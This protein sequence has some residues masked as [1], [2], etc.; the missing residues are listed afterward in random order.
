MSP[1]SDALQLFI[2]SAF[3]AFDHFAQAP[4]SRRSILQISSALEVPGVERRGHGSRLPVCSHVEPALSIETEHEPLRRLIDRFRAV[5]PFLA[6][7]RRT[8]CDGSASA[9]FLEGHA[10]AMIVGPGGLE[11]RRDVWL[12]LH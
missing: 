12:G 4:Q 2:D 9:N 5:E 7:R 6:W 1:R 3:E 10:N 11:E 8:G